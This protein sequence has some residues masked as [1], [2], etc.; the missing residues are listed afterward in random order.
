MYTICIYRYSLFLFFFFLVGRQISR[1]KMYSRHCKLSYFHLPTNN[2]FYIPEQCCKSDSAMFTWQGMQLRK[3][4]KSS[5]TRNPKRTGR[6]QTFYI[7]NG[8]MLLLL[9]VSIFCVRAGC[10]VNQVRY[11]ERNVSD[12]SMPDCFVVKGCTVR[13]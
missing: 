9:E 6:M 10:N 11:N 3:H 13:L 4:A 7:S 12:A 1:L 2:A 8:C 5:Y